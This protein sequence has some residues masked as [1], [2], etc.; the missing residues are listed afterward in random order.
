MSVLI[1]CC[2]LVTG[3]ILVIR[4]TVHGLEEG[5][6]LV[7]IVETCWDWLFQREIPS[8]PSA[9]WTSLSHSFTILYI[10]CMAYKIQTIY[11]LAFMGTNRRP[12][13]WCFRWIR[14]KWFGI[15]LFTYNHVLVFG[16]PRKAFLLKLFLS[17]SYG[18]NIIKFS[19][20]LP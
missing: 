16:H 18:L 5:D 20:T 2:Y 6:G 3:F 19:S 8:N 4:C 7:V 10:Q 14:S 1:C 11:F 12:L 17:L 15:Q 13:L 9:F